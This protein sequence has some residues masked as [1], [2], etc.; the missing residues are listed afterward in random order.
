M[1]TRSIEAELLQDTINKFN[2]TIA[3]LP[4]YALV[5]FLQFENFKPLKSIQSLI[6][7]GAVVSNKLCQQFKPFIPNGNIHVLYGSTEED[8]LSAN[9]TNRNYGSS[10]FV[11]SNVELKVCFEYFHIYE[12]LFLL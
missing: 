9:Y 4:P 1:I 8:F 5:S 2:V 6:V 10:G 7:G 12:D 3:I 11:R